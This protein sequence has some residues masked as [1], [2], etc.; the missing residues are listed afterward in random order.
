MKVLLL[1]CLTFGQTRLVQGNLFHLSRLSEP[2]VALPF[3][4]ELRAQ[5][6]TCCLRRPPEDEG[7]E[8]DEERKARLAKARA[9]HIAFQSARLN[10]SGSRVESQLGHFFACACRALWRRAI[11]PTLTAV[12]CNLQNR[13][14]AAQARAKAKRTASLR[15]R[16][17]WRQ[18]INCSNLLSLGIDSVTTH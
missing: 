4:S 10:W 17:W 13:Q 9:A 6:F 2:C 11:K 12:R 8:E 3:Q 15:L 7:G 16:C 5:L 14:M 1:S 18:E